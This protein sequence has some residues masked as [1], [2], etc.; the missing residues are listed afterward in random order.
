MFDIL[1]RMRDE[2]TLAVIKEE[3]AKVIAFLELLASHPSG[4]AP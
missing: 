3:E 4:Y 2:L 1:Q